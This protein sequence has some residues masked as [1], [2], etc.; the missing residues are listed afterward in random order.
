MMS[1]GFYLYNVMNDRLMLKDIIEKI[2]IFVYA[3]NQD[4]KNGGYSIL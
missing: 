3:Y 1:E 4:V 2:I